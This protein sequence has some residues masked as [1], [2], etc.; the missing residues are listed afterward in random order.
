MTLQPKIIFKLSLSE[1]KI[2]TDIQYI[3][4]IKK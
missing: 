1:S 3:L 2:D 4:Q